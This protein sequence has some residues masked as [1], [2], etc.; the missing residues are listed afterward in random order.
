MHDM[1]S[2]EVTVLNCKIDPRVESQNLMNRF[3]SNLVLDVQK[4]IIKAVETI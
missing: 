4:T 3:R 1:N 2:D